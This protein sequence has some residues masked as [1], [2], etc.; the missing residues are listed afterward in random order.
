MP[1]LTLIKQADNDR[2]SR[3]EMSF[4]VDSSV[5]AQEYFEDF[6]KAAGFVSRMPYEQ[7][8]Y[9]TRGE[10]EWDHNGELIKPK[11]DLKVVE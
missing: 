7:T 11:A 9:L 8:G 4:D 6:L 5:L 2:D 3:I 10:M 1:K